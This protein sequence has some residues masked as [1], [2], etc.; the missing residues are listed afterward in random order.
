MEEKIGWIELN[1]GTM[2]YN[3]KILLTVKSYCQFFDYLVA[4]KLFLRK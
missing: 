2:L 3:L 1:V 4:V